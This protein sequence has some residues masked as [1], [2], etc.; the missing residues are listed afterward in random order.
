[1]KRIYALILA[2]CCLQT[3]CGED[4]DDIRADAEA[5]AQRVAALESDVAKLN[6]EIG[7]LHTLMQGKAVIVGYT[8]M[9]E[10]AGYRLELSDGKTITVWHGQEILHAQP[11]YGVDA[12]GNWIYSTD[13]GKTFKPVT[14]ADGNTM[15]I[16]PVDGATGETGADGVTPQVKIDPRGYWMVSLDGGKNYEYLLGTDGKM[17]NA[18]SSSEGYSGFFSNVEFDAA[19]NTLVLT[20]K[21]DG[22]EIRLPVTD[23]FALT[24]AHDNAVEYFMAGEKRTFAVEQTGVAEA[25]LLVPTG[26]T[27]IL[28]ETQLEVTAPNENSAGEIKIALVSEKHYLRTVA[29]RVASSQGTLAWREFCNGS[30]DNVL[31]DFSYAGYKHGEV[32]PPDVSTLGYKEYNICD[33]GAVPNDGKSDRAAFKK[34]LEAIGNK[35][36]NAKA[37]L[38]FPEGEFELHAESDDNGGYS[39][40]IIINM[41]GFVLKG[42]GRDKTTILMSAPNTTPTPQ[43]MWTSPVL[44]NIKHNSGLVDPTD[45][46]AD[47]AKGTFAVEVAS[48]SGLKAGEWVALTL[49][50][51]D[52]ALVQQELGSKERYDNLNF[53]DYQIIKEGVTI[54]DYHQI[55]SVNGN[56]V[57]FVEP[58]MHAVEA[59]WGWKIQ[60]Y[61]H[62]ENVGVEDI[63]FKGN[64]KA[65]FK[66]H[67]SWD[68]DGGYK[69]INLMRL[70]DS[71]MRRVRFE[72]VS[73]CSSI[74]TCANVSV[75]DVEIT[76]KRGHSAIRSQGSSR[77]FIGKV[78][79]KSTGPSDANASYII[80]GAGQY[81]AVG[82]SKQSMGAVLWRNEWGKDSNF[83]SHATQPR[84]T[85]IDCC[86]GAFL[87]SRQG[88]DNNQMPNHLDDLTV[89]NFVETVAEPSGM[90]KWW[91]FS[92]K[93]W[94]FLP[95]TFVGYQGA[96][97]FDPATVKRDE[98]HGEQVVP[99]S[100]YEAQLER[101]LGSVPAWLLELK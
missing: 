38:Y 51:N 100:L 95:P 14:D 1:M 63:T 92:S 44:L 55:K 88:G 37:I 82:I 22:S 97:T 59:K 57:T 74:V 54:Q 96:N 62:Y 73:E 79:D 13:G 93:W 91:D 7:N 39:S 26:W 6:Q 78:T 60:K 25:T 53:A 68:D 32:A 89:W 85:L 23:D 21:S 80:E 77:V 66:H 30:A 99:Q 81:H 42:A 40:D 72:S 58:L 24:I 87:K 11:I 52:P 43:N 50:N 101:R 75:Y 15:R 19:T 83:E 29:L 70:T 47:A 49:A 3:S 48:T 27:A 8:P 71:W 36:P 33:Y 45:V 17:M 20:R 28:K 16:A 12:D 65:D 18:T 61:N 84:A 94:K 41:G 10:N 90:I 35:I 31:L 9:P 2:L 56:T 34:M 76:G 64:A 46:T 69:P 86:T 98:A 5:L 4:L 67:A